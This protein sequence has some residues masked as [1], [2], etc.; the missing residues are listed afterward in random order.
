[1]IASL[2]ILINPLVLISVL[3]MMRQRAPPEQDAS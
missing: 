1:V 2:F 3:H